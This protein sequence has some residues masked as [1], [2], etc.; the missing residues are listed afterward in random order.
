LIGHY[1]R[2]RSHCDEEIGEQEK[3]A[4]GRNDCNK[5]IGEPGKIAGDR[6]ASLRNWAKKLV[7]LLIRLLPM[8]PKGSGKLSEEGIVDRI[9][10]GRT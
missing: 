7:I 9:Y 1:P 8:P 2:H 3:I 4:G 6:L 10:S 5:E